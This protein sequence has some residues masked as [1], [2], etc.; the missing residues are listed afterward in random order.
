[1]AEVEEYLILKQLTDVLDTLDI[2][3]A[4]GGSIASSVYGTVRFTQDADINV[5]AFSDKAEGFYAALERDFYISKEAMHQ[6]ISKHTSF[7][8]IHLAAAFKIDIFVRADED[9]DRQLFRRR[10]KVKLDE[11]LDHLFDVVSAED[12][13]LLKL[14]WYEASGGSSERQWSDAVGII[15]VQRDSLDMEY[16][17]AYSE[18]LGLGDILQ[19]AIRESQ[20]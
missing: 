6:A 4:I 16:L 13:I 11:S 18:R 1:M 17:G 9:F 3:Y 8:V 20:T 2:R 14:Q 15:A 12:I 5:V 7:N 10:N 19:K